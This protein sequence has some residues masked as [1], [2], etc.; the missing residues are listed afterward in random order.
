M[1]TRGFYQKGGYVMGRLRDGSCGAREKGYV[2]RLWPSRPSVCFRLTATTPRSKPSRSGTRTSRDGDSGIEYRHTRPQPQALA[3]FCNRNTA[4]YTDKPKIVVVSQ[5]S[6][7]RARTS[8][9]HGVPVLSIGAAFHEAMTTTVAC[10]V[11]WRSMT[12]ARTY[13]SVPAGAE[14]QPAG[15]PRRSW[16]CWVGGH[17]RVAP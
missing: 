3:R 11:S 8:A 9:A 4:T 5:R 7:G 17:Y 16:G 13:R 15:F 12:A 6:A 14:H 2:D 10:A 1:P